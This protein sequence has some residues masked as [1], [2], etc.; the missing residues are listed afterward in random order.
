[1]ESTLRHCQAFPDQNWK[2]ADFYP[3]NS[4]SRYVVQNCIKTID[5]N[6]LQEY[7]SRLHNGIKCLVLPGITNGQ[8][9]LVSVLEF[10]NKTRWVAR[11]QM[12]KSTQRL[13]AEL[14]REVDVMALMRERT[15]IPLPQVFGYE[16]DDNNQ[17]GVAFVLMEFLPDNVAMDADG[18][19]EAHR[20]QIPLQRR[21]G[22][23]DSTAH[24]Q[25]SKQV[26]G[27]DDVGPFAK[28][29]DSFQE[30]RRQ[31]EAGPFPDIG[32][33]FET[34]TAF[35]EAWAAHASFPMSTTEIRESMKNG[36]VDEV[37]MSITEFPL[38]VKEFASRLSSNDSG[39][40]PVSHQDFLHSNI[41]VNDRY[42]IL[43]VI[44]WEGA[45]TVPWE[46]VE[47][48]LFLST[49]PLPMDAPWNYDQDGEP[50]DED[51]RQTWRERKEYIERAVRFEIIEGIDDR[52]SATLNDQTLQNLA[53]AMRVYSEIGKL[54][55]YHKVME[56]FEKKHVL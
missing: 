29:R 6:A 14:Q 39:P 35:F 47:F 56:P 44:D 38:K 16:I 20:G 48:P 45:C 8:N 53:Y 21:D 55:F 3:M 37:L 36:P 33:P 42:R 24:V 26:A 54:G 27:P 18:G 40:F 17:T 11:I 23:Y 1:M 10:E 32:G 46:L 34:A 7:A 50:L 9:H 5:W 30:Q 2:G 13:A 49:V 52:L 43:G 22:F 41:I 15:K 4:H 28:D 12:Y 19:Y 31:L 25:S 51:T